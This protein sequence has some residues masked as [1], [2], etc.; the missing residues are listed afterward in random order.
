MKK[1]DKNIVGLTM[2]IAGMIGM[3]FNVEASGWITFLGVFL[4]L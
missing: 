1:I 2:I 4:V 3:H